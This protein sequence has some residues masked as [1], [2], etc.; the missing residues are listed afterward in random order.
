[1]KHKPASVNKPRT[2]EEIR[3]EATNVRHHIG[4]IFYLFNRLEDKFVVL[5]KLEIEAR[6]SIAY[7]QSRE[8]K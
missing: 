8:K 5:D 4:E 2:V 7:Y 1:M 6:A 3:Q